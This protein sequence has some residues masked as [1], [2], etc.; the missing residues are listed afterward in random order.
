MKYIF[1]IVAVVL[2]ILSGITYMR[3]PDQ[4]TDV[5]VIYWVTDP[6]PARKEQ[7]AAFTK[8]Q[9]KHGH[10]TADGKPVVQIKVDAA[11]S[12]TGK[13]IIQSVSGVGGDTMDLFNGRHIRY[14]NDI[15][16][17]EDLTED[18]KKMK[19][20]LS[21][22]YAALESELFVDG[23]QYA[24]PCNLTSFMYWVNKDAFKAQG[25]PLPPKSWTWEEF[26]RMGKAF[27]GAANKPGETRLYFYADTVDRTQ[28]HRSLG[29][30]IFNET[31]T[32]CTLDDERYV[33]TL[34]KIYQWMFEDQ[35]IPTEAAILAFNT[36]SG[37]AGSTPQLLYRGNFAM[38]RSGRFMLIQFRKFEKPMDLDVAELPYGEFRNATIATRAASVYVGGKNK[39]LT[40]LF[41]A[42]LASEDYN[43]HLVKDADA[44]PPNPKYAETEEFRRPKGHENE[45]GTHERFY[46][47]ANTI[48]I[49]SV[50]SPFVMDIT[51]DRISKR[52]YEKV[53]NKMS[54]PEEAATMTKKLIDR[55]IQRT[56]HEKPWLNEDYE[57]S[58]ADQKKIDRLKAEGKKI[59]LSL[60]RNSFYKRYY[61]EMGM[62]E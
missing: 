49:G 44:L 61:K 37:Y 54:S 28:M 51:V 21:Q 46:E 33:K 3:F 26:E 38:I 53:I 32:E 59:P 48:A 19:F 57:K 6:N 20:D 23:K 2:G 42:F 60:V 35:I 16:I 58:V 22:T 29:L 56:L 18:A 31:M 27:V 11:N 62:A 55:E 8:W 5:P 30:S 9:L 50:Y 1:L 24:F 7:I 43:M 14:F 4:N 15:G 12:S 39:E 36:E 34:A 17:L 45:W 41:L 25:Q 10:V 13:K 52:W 47:Q 40:K